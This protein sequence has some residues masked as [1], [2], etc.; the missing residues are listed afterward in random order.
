[1]LGVRERKTRWSALV[2]TW[3]VCASRIFCVTY[4]G[5]M[6]SSD[7][8]YPRA[9]SKKLR[10]CDPENRLQINV[11]R[12]TRVSIGA[13]ECIMAKRRTIPLSVPFFRSTILLLLC[14]RDGRAR[15]AMPCV[16][17]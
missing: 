9:S 5:G 3:C 4:V 16:S 17:R 2:A 11:A 15:N 14:R 12:D 1:M 10:V 8:R 6:P 13:F 7:G